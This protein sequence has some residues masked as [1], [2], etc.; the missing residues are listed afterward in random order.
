MAR[1]RLLLRACAVHQ[2]QGTS[3]TAANQQ[4]ASAV[5]TAGSAAAPGFVDEPDWADLYAFAVQQ[6][7]QAAQR[8]RYAGYTPRLLQLAAAFDL[9]AFDLDLFLLALLPAL[10]PGIGRVLCLSAG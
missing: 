2:E 7:A 1:V 9:D 5:S 3:Q 4:L 6:S 10:D 8:A